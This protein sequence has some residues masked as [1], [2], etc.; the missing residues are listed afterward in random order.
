[1]VSEDAATDLCQSVN[2][3]S[4]L[5]SEDVLYVLNG[6]VGVLHHVVEQC[7]TDARRTESHLLAGDLRH[8]DGVHDVWFARESAHAFMGLSGEVE[9]FCDNVNLFPVAGV[10]VGIEQMVEGI[11][12]HFVVSLFTL[13]VFQL[14]FVHSSLVLQKTVL[15]CVG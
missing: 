6:V 14:L 13:L 3:L 15:S 10:Q 5:R 7:S 12:Y 4:N 11:C 1:M 9:R 8:G 2:N